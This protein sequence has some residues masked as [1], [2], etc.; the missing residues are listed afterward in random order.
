MQ[1]HGEWFCDFCG[2]QLTPDRIDGKTKR[3]PWADMCAPCHHDFGVGFGTGRG[4]RFDVVTGKKLE[5]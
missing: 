5:G 1:E 4:Q 2:T 3:G